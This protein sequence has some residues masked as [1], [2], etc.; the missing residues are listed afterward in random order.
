MSGRGAG[1]VS[2]AGSPS[3][4]R[5]AAPPHTLTLSVLLPACPGRDYAD[6]GEEVQISHYRI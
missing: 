5:L 4:T 3:P 2:S 1:A 6:L